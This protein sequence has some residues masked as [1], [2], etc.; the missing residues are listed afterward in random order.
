MVRRGPRVDVLRCSFCNKSQRDVRK[1]IAGP[2]VQICDECLE[3]CN[4]I[5]AEDKV[6][7]VGEKAGP[8]AVPEVEAPLEAPVRCRLCQ[9]LFPDSACVAFPDRGWVCQSC[10]DH[11]RLYL[12]SS[13]RPPL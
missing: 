3:I 5:V 11:L 8:D 7:E 9:Q 1:L 13:E 4:G 2:E 10:L 6:L 12:E